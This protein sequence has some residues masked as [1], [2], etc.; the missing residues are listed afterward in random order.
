MIILGI[1]LGTSRTGICILDN[2]KIL[3]KNVHDYPVPWSDTKLRA[4]LSNFRSYF[5]RYAIIGVIVK[6][7]PP[8]RH[9]PALKRLMRRI[10]ALARDHYCEVDFITK[11][12]IK[13][14]YVLQSTDEIIQFA[15]KMHPE[16]LELYQRGIK[17]NHK[18]HKKLYEAVLAAHIFY[19]RLKVKYLNRKKKHE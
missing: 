17:S 4:I 6:V 15:T 9:T 11:A 16:L 7:P 5:K 10:E 1:S 12:E 18:F 19:N 2:E 8:S 3:A 13:G 14:T